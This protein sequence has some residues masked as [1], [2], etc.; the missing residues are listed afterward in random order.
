VRCEIWALD[1]EAGEAILREGDLW[2][3]S[4]MDRKWKP[5][6]LE[7]PQGILEWSL[8]RAVV[9]V[10]RGY[11]TRDEAVIIARQ[12]CR[13]AWRAGMTSPDEID[14]LL[15]EV[16]AERGR[17]RAGDPAEWSRR[18][19][20]FLRAALE[21]DRYFQVQ[22]CTVE[23][24]L[25]WTCRTLQKLRESDDWPRPGRELSLVLG[26]LAGAVQRE[27]RERREEP[28]APERRWSDYERKRLARDLDRLSTGDLEML[29]CW[30]D[31]SYS[32]REIA[33]LL[34]VASEEV[35]RTLGLVSESMSRPLAELRTAAFAEICKSALR[36]R[37]G[38]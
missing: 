3:L 29:T 4:A 16:E 37:G 18:F 12:V 17:R 20:E 25:E 32:E 7:S 6:E 14:R 15:D 31:S 22:G 13:H 26:R 1:P 2:Y 8:S 23:E 27:A 11:G 38:A 36:R 30:A 24:S 34:Q 33:T 35:E 19:P 9:P 5:V 10:G 28:A 21:L